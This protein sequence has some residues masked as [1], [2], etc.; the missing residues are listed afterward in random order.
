MS[1]DGA[2]LWMAGISKAAIDQTNYYTT[3]YDKGGL[4]GNGW[5]NML[6]NTILVCVCVCVCVCARE[7]YMDL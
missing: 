1:R 5:C 2:V 4:F 7:V 6:A 3:Q